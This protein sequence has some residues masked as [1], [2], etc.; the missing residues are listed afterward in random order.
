[1]AT[2]TIISI[3]AAKQAV[4]AE[5][6]STSMVDVGSEILDDIIDCM[7]M[8][9]K[10]RLMSKNGGHLPK[11]TL[12]YYPV[13]TFMAERL[14]SHLFLYQ[15]LIET[16]NEDGPSVEEREKIRELLRGFEEKAMDDI[17]KKADSDNEFSEVPNCETICPKCGEKMV[18]QKAV[19]TRSA[20]EPST[21]MEKCLNP[22][23]GW[24]TRHD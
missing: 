18:W 5:I 12:D 9:I 14:T 21:V 22:T 8:H 19:Q 17:I 16:L 7:W 20:D 4:E 23:C 2:S 11:L 10:D 24:C 15:E 1:M 13:I 6:V 3:G